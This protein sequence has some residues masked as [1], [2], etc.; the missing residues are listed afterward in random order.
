MVDEKKNIHAKKNLFNGNSKKSHELFTVKIYEMK[1][2]KLL[3]K[4]NFLLYK[5]YDI[6]QIKNQ[7]ISNCPFNMNTK[8]N[9]SFFESLHTG[10]FRIN[11]ITRIIKVS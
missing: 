9:F 5:A 11:R 7:D 2:K 3:S 6:K 10:N 1:T 4:I 8:E